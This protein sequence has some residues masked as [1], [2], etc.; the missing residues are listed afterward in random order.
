MKHPPKEVGPAGD[1]PEPNRR[2]GFN[3]GET[4]SEKLCCIKCGC[5]VDPAE[6]IGTDHE[7]AVPW[8][9]PVCRECG[10]EAARETFPG[11]FGETW[12]ERRARN[13]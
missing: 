5:C 12:S 2:D 11:E 7:H 9:F 1:R 6:I 8:R 4:L 10:E 13:V 3:G